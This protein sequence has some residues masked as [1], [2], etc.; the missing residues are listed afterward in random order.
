MAC[1]PPSNPVITVSA[2]HDASDAATIASAALPPSARISRPAAAVAGCPAATAASIAPVLTAGTPGRLQA[3]N[4]SEQT[5]LIHARGLVKR[6]GDLVA[7]D[8]I[9]FDVH[10]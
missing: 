7:V 4:V 6:F 3:V 1:P 9:D 10:K 2:T 8:G 5:P